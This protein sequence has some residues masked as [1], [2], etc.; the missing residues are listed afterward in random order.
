MPTS[1]NY[2][3]TRSQPRA[4]YLVALVSF[5][6]AAFMCLD[7]Q[8]SLHLTY[9]LSSPFRRKPPLQWRTRSEALIECAKVKKPILYV[10]IQKG[11]SFAF[12]LESEGLSNPEVSAYINENFLPVRAEIPSGYS[13]EVTDMKLGEGFKGFTDQ[14]GARRQT[15]LFVVPYK[16]AR[17]KSDEITSSANLAELGRNRN[18]DFNNHVYG[19]GYEYAYVDDDY[20]YSGYRGAPALRKAPYL[21]SYRD[22]PDLMRYLYLAR[23]WHTLKPTRGDI[24]WLSHEVLNQPNS[25]DKPRLLVMVNDCGSASDSFRLSCLLNPDVRSLIE[26]D[27]RPIFVE[28]HPYEPEK[29][30]SIQYLKEQYDLRA[31]HDL[32]AVIKVDNQRSASNIL[33]GNIYRESLID[34]LREQKVQDI[35]TH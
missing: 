7:K 17:A 29:D 14:L 31:Q 24:K 26:S 13:N 34:F 25:G 33:R 19:D 8:F 10:L 9:D 16:L 12:R 30:K 22:I 5:G 18:S 35:E 11:E 21:N 1:K 2:K 6:L 27:Y 20:R 15:G 23:S 3:G 28:F 4:L 32:P